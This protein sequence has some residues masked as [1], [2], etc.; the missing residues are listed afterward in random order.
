[1]DTRTRVTI[2]VPGAKLELIERSY[3]YYRPSTRRSRYTARDY[4]SDWADYIQAPRMYVSVADESVLENLENRRRRPYNV[5]KK[6]IAASGISSVLNLQNLAW[7]QGAGCR[8]CPCSPGFILPKQ[9]LSVGELK[10][11]QF[12]VW[13]TLDGAPNVDERKPARVVV[14]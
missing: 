14:I 13:V 5:Y 3:P 12:D 8:M 10:F 7:R 6:M 9:E 11:K 4:R 2:S 1:M